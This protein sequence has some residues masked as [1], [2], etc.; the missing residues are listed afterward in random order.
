MRNCSFT[1]HREIEEK[2]IKPLEEILVR[3]ID[4]VYSEGCRN[5]Y[6]GGA[7]GFDTMA[8]KTVIAMKLKKPD[9]RLIVVIPCKSQADKWSERAR[10]IYE[11]ILSNAD[12]VVY[13]SEEYT[14][15]CMRKRNQFLVDSCDVLVAFSG[16]ERSGSAQT[17]RMAVAKE[18][19]V[20]NL[21]RKIVDNT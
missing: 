16:K 12:E 3:A 8:A 4:Y 11:F 14:K 19:I 1:G 13:T 10:S 2:Y 20:Y 6:C 18:R 17:V 21:Y 5:F 7:V 9:M 15:D